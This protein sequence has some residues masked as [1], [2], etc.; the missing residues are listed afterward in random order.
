MVQLPIGRHLR[1]VQDTCGFNLQQQ[2]GA[3]GP[4]EEPRPAYFKPESVDSN[5]QEDRN[6]VLKSIK[7]HSDTCVG[8]V[9]NVSTEK[10]LKEFHENLTWGI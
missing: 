10:L 6:T 9:Q 2:R 3:I 7:L 8:I 4:L 5:G 1:R